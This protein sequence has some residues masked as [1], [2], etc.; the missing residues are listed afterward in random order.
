[1]NTNLSLTTIKDLNS[2]DSSGVLLVALEI[3]IPNTP[4]VR[5]VANN[6]N[7]TYKN[8]LYVAFP[9]EIG[10][11]SVAKGESPVFTLNI[12]N[13]SKAIQKY[14]LAYDEYLKSNKYEQETI[15]AKLH[16][17]NTK[18]LSNSILDEEFELTDFHSNSKEVVFNLGVMSLFNLSYPPRKMYKD[19]C[20]FK[21]KDEYCNYKGNDTNCNKSLQDCR[22]KN[23]SVR[24]GGFLGIAGGYKI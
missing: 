11:L 12:D 20:P 14:I 2:L 1:M 22:A 19:Y 15:K 9:F 16:L 3:F 21:F 8:E 4:V 6:E 18:D 17:L 24:F 7:I 23:N 10:E 5:I 13:T